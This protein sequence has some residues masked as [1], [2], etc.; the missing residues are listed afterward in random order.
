MKGSVPSGA[1]VGTLVRVSLNESKTTMVFKCGRSGPLGI[2]ALTGASKKRMPVSVPKEGRAAR[3][4]RAARARCGSKVAAAARDSAWRREARSAEDG[5]AMQARTTAR[6]KQRIVAAEP[7]EITI[8]RVPEN[9]RHARQEMTMKKRVDGAAR[10]AAP[11]IQGEGGDAALAPAPTADAPTPDSTPTR[12][13]HH[14]VVRKVVRRVHHSKS[15]EG[16]ASPCDDPETPLGDGQHSPGGKKVRRVVRRVV[17]RRSSGDGEP[18]SAESREPGS[19]ESQPGSAGS[20]DGD[21]VVSPSGKKLRRVIRRVPSR[22]S[23][24]AG[25]SEDG[26]GESSQPPPPSPPDDD[27]EDA[28]PGGDG[29]GKKVRK[30]VRRVRRTSSGASE[31]GGEEPIVID[32]KKVRK[33]IRRV[34]RTHATERSSNVVR[35]EDELPPEQLLGEGIAAVKFRDAE[36]PALALPGRPPTCDP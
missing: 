31:A 17:R 18:G 1:S 14:K 27:A 3:R 24:G 23:S 33:V 6:C 35:V 29:D 16:P 22:R 36:A 28:T 5:A 2:S 26:D 30:V 25:G 7:L 8:E 15:G 19:A 12:H 11:G 20:F 9:A 10:R 32:G 34:K 13:K 4:A 21:V